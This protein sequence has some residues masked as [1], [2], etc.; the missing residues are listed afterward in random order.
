LFFFWIVLSILVLTVL[1][2]WRIKNIKKI[3]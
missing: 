1:Q 3:I 2:P